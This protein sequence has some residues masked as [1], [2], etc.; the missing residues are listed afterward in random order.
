MTQWTNQAYTAFFHDRLQIGLSVNQRA[1]LNA[2]G[3]ELP[4]DLL[5]LRTTDNWKR[6]QDIAKKY[7]IP[8]A[9][10]Q[11]RGRRAAAEEEEQNSPTYAP[12]GV[13][14]IEM[15]NSDP[16]SVGDGQNGRVTPTLLALQPQQMHKMCGW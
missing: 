7:V 1:S 9:A 14:S 8:S 15:M 10:G 5:E 2:A 3:V 11:P 13:K 16:I 4:E 12:L 6:I